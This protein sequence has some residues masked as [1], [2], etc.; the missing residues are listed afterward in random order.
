[1]GGLSS[2]SK[3]GEVKIEKLRNQI[4][5]TLGTPVRPIAYSQV[6]FEISSSLACGRDLHFKFSGLKRELYQ[7]E[8][9]RLLPSEYRKLYCKYLMNLF[10]RLV[11]SND[12]NGI[13]FNILNLPSPKC[14]FSYPSLLPLHFD[15][16]IILSLKFTDN[17]LDMLENL[18]FLHKIRC[19]KEYG[20]LFLVDIENELIDLNKLDQFDYIR[21][22]QFMANSILSNQQSIQQQE[23]IG[24]IE[25]ANGA[26]K[27][28]IL[29][30]L[31][32]AESI[33]NLN[34]VLASYIQ[35]DFINPY[36][37]IKLR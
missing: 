13:K 2:E 36:K 4:Y 16:T 23:A 5:Q 24:L 27:S 37:I 29:S 30:G 19:L 9:Y 35:G 14:I 11:R 26:N 3:E 15:G 1:M 32:D 21:F 6:I 31:H 10:I 17:D 28:I 12:S 34:G 33:C 25:G 7:D 18:A 22:G 20:A 8:L